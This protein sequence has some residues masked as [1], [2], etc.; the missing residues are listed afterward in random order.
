MQRRKSAT[1]S[2]R[3]DAELIEGLKKA[4]KHEGVS[5]NSF[6]ESVLSRRVRADPIIHAFPY[7]ILSRRSFVPIL[8]TSDPDSLELV[9]SE[10]GKRNFAF[11]R[12]LYGSSGTTLGFSQYLIEVLGEQAHWFETEGVNSMPER[13]TLRHEYGLKW[14]LFL[15]SFLT[16]AYEVVSHDR[17]KTSLTDAYVGIELPK[18]PR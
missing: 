1:S 6:V 3:F 17:M 15:K 12:E 18:L 5:E 2:F 10:L 7:I 16:G 8:G 14:S 13:M 9:A 11:A 4:A